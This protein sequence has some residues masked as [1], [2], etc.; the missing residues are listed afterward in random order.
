MANGEQPPLRYRCVAAFIFS[1]DEL[2]YTTVQKRV[3]P[4]RGVKVQAECGCTLYFACS[5]TVTCTGCGPARYH[6]HT[7]FLGVWGMGSVGVHGWSAGSS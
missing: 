7:V 4:L 5:V 6:A 1:P 2:F 3:L